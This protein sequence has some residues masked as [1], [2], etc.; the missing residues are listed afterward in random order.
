[1]TP[2]SVA[3]A[4][5]SVSESDS[6]KERSAA[7]EA[8]YAALPGGLVI[9]CLLPVMTMEDGAG[10]VCKWERKIEIPFV[11]PKMLV[12][13]DCRDSNFISGV[14]MTFR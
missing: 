14:H 3:G 6:A 13:K 11:T 1:M 7:L 2:C 8:L 12:C 5:D 10:R 9:P 4:S